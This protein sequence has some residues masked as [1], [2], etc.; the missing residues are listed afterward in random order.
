MNTAQDTTNILDAGLCVHNI[1][2]SYKKKPVLRDVSLQVRK[3]E[4][5]GLLG[6]NGA[7]KTTSFYIITGL[8]QPDRGMITLDEYNITKLPMYRRADVGIG[9]LAQ[10]PSIFRGLSVRDNILAVLEKNYPDVEQR[11]NQLASLMNDFSISH[12]AHTPSTA[13]SGGE[14]R[15]L[16]IARVLASDPSYVLLDEPLAGVDPI[17]VGEIRELIEQLKTRNIGVLITDHNVR[18]T[19][20]I[21]DRAYILHDG[22]VLMAGTPKEI[23]KSDA[24]RTVYLGDSFN[25]EI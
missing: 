8:I 7:G 4:A 17:A 14:R 3:G 21:V 6:P 23:I 1:A 15:R 5:V 25:I 10:E 13:L 20:G 16:E 12:L 11:H 2:K 22:Q 18:E 24:V 9:Y 19:L